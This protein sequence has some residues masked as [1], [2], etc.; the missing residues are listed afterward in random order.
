MFGV[1]GSTEVEEPLGVLLRPAL[2]EGPVLE[3]T[4]NP[5]SVKKGKKKK[6]AWFPS[7][8][9]GTSSCSVQYLPVLLNQ[10][11]A[12]TSAG[13]QGLSMQHSVAMTA[14]LCCPPLPRTGRSPL[15]PFLPQSSEA[16]GE[17]GPSG[18]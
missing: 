17:P 10:G 13:P 7:S 3:E 2:L 15:L 12:Q 6:L 4:H 8:L 5:W 11:F 18:S 1:K 16:P 14:A 9:I